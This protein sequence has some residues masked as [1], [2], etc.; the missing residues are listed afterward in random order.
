MYESLITH[1]DYLSLDVTVSL[2]EQNVE[3][4]PTKG[5]ILS[6]QYKNFDSLRDLEAKYRLLSTASA[7]MSIQL[8]LTTH[9]SLF[10]VS[11]HSLASNV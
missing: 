2:L 3:I 5:K 1:A 9:E 6:N 11:Y 10:P 7:S 8:Q 4:L